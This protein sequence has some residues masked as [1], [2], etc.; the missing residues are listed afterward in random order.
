MRGLLDVLSRLP[1]IAPLLVEGADAVLDMRRI[2]ETH[3]YVV[4]LSAAKIT[5]SLI[6]F[7]RDIKRRFPH[8]SVIVMAGDD[9]LARVSSILRAGADSYLHKNLAP[10]T[11][12]NG[13]ARSL[14]GERLA[15]VPDPG[16]WLSRIVRLQRPFSNGSASRNRL[17][18]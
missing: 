9:R 14:R 7:V 17:K 2:E 15:A 8:V 11:F 12:D 6:S 3:P 4:L 5:T 1:D 10:S 16:W 18:G 13:L